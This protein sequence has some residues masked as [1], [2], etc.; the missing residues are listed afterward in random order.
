MSV[1]K[2]ALAGVTALLLSGCAHP[3]MFA[4]TMNGAQ[5][6]PPTQ[7][8]GTG[9]MSAMVYPS[10]RRMTYTVDYAG[11]SGPATAAHFH[12]PAAVGANGGVAVPFASSASPISGGATLT[13][14]Q[15]DDVMAGK[16]YANVHTAANPNGE[17]RGQLLPGVMPK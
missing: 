5:V 9:T 14:E 12:G 16:W 6:V 3:M 7:S 4:G 11:L 2:L 17:I 10:T 8:A 13:P 15:L 1:S